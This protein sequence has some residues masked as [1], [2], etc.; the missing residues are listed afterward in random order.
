M[1][2]RIYKPL[3]KLNK[4]QIK[5]ILENGTLEQLRIFPLSIGE[6]LNWH[7]VEKTLE[8]LNKGE[9]L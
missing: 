7:L 9:T 8:K 6:Y 4:K 2:E 3:K 1:Q 5:T